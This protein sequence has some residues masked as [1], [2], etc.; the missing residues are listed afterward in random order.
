MGAERQRWWGSLDEDRFAG[1]IFYYQS[2]NYLNNSAVSTACGDEPG[3][4]RDRDPQSSAHT[5]AALGDQIQMAHYNDITSGGHNN[6]NAHMVYSVQYRFEMFANG[7]VDE[8]IM[9]MKNSCSQPDC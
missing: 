8:K 7:H 3:T 5:P 4:W 2:D 6:Y 1:A 9:P